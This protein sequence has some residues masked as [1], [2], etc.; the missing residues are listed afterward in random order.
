[1][2]I[3]TSDRLDITL[4][5]VKPDDADLLLAIF[6]G[7]REKERQTVQWRP[8]EWA[9]FVRSQQE[10]QTAHYSKHFAEASH[11]I[12]LCLGIPVGSIWVCRSRDEIRLLDLA[13]LPGYR[14][15]GIGTHLIHRLQAEAI[16]LGKQLRHTVE[17]DNLSALRFYLRLGFRKVDEYG[18]HISMEWNGPTHPV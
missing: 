5:D 18:L 8:A 16:E 1:M 14:S 15:K 10:L 17:S 2:A 13:I 6:A 9:D 11:R 7:T 3:E 12:I 4:R